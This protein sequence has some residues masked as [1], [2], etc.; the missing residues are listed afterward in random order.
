MLY[1]IHPHLSTVVEIGKMMF[2][3]KF[4]NTK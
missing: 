4:N 3:D 1:S 2:T